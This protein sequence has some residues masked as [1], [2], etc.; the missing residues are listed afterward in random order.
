MD[1][2]ITSAVLTL[3]IA[4]TI[5]FVGINIVSS[6]VDTTADN[7]GYT[8]TAVELDGT[9]WVTIADTT[10][11]QERVFDSRGYAIELTGAN[12]SYIQSTDDIDIEDA[13]NWTVSVWASRDSN[14][15]QQAVTTV[16]GDIQIAYNSSRDEWTGWYYDDGARASYRVN[17]SATAGTGDLANI[18]LTKN[19][20][21]LTIYENN[22]AG[23][24]ENLDGSTS[25]PF[26][27]SDNWDGRIDELRV[28]NQTLNNTQRQSHYDN[29]IDPIP[30]NAQGRVMFDEPYTSPQLYIYNPGSVET[31]NA[32]F[33][34]GL[35]GQR[36]VTDELLAQ[37]DYQWQSDGPRIRAVTGGEL[38]NAPVAYVDYKG[39]GLTDSLLDSYSS[40]IV[41]AGLLLILVPVGVVFAYLQGMRGR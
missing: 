30:G 13:P 19:Q 17:V 34:Q 5:L 21:N 32:T 39:L 26:V 28:W 1:S 38:E 41:L 2:K 11:T 16:D 25:E 40:A 22:T 8:Q 14:T 20:S 31:F 36:L 6:T 12:D 29:P 33:A 9:D 35:P 37:N 15:G 10:G 24:T 18:I 3:V 7:T 27:S 4:G 23:E